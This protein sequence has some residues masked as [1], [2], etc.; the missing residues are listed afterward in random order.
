MNLLSTTLVNN[1]LGAYTGKF[2]GSTQ[3]I[4]AQ[5]KRHLPS[6]FSA[7]QSLISGTGIVNIQ[8]I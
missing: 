3:N 1:H 8:T 4:E 5:N 2:I 6:S 7:T